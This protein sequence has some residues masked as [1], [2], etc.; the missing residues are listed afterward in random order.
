MSILTLYLQSNELKKFIE[1][2]RNHFRYFQ[3]EMMTLRAE[4]RCEEMKWRAC[5]FHMIG[6]LMQRYYNQQGGLHMIEYMWHT[7]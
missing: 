1:F 2:Y 5:W 3:K 4:L 6:T 7:Q